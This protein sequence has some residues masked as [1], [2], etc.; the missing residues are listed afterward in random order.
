MKVCATLTAMLLLA[1][2]AFAADVDGKWKGYMSTPSGDKD[3]REP[4][5]DASKS[6]C[7]LADISL[8]R[9]LVPLCPHFVLLAFQP[10]LLF[11]ATL[12]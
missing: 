11:Q 1:V 2:S 8:G 3:A 9:R 4:I 12:A 6:K 10:R 7:E 5:R